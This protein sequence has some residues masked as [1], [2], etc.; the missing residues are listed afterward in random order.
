VAAILRE[1]LREKDLAGRLGGEEFAVILP[2]T[3][4]VGAQQLAE[5][6]R[7]AM[8]ERVRI[9]GSGGETVT[10]SIGVAAVPPDETTLDATLSRADAALY[11]AK[12]KG[13]NR[14]VVEANASQVS[15]MK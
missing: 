3:N 4:V 5:R 11:E 13:R 10:I 9:P 8:A 12:E 15:G 7:Q 1:T 2:G 14:V 6:L